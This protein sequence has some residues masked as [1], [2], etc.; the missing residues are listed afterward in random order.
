MLTWLFLDAPRQQRP[1]IMAGMIPKTV[2]NLS[3]HSDSNHRN[4]SPSPHSKRLGSGGD[5]KTRY[6]KEL[7]EMRLR[8]T[9]ERTRTDSERTLTDNESSNHGYPTGSNSSRMEYYG[10]PKSASIGEYCLILVW[11]SQLS[12]YESCNSGYI[13]NRWS[14]LWEQNFNTYDNE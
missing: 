12:D 3:R 13:V 9:S 10:I 7:E 11:T 14:I 6:E 4:M 8:T 1:S 5:G 2:E